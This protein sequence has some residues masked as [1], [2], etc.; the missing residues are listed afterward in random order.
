M[1]LILLK[2]H[3]AYIHIFIENICQIYNFNELTFSRVTFIENNLQ[4]AVID[5][6]RF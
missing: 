1:N 2:I 3:E 5:A 4:I 6:K